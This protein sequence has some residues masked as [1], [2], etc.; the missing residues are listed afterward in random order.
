MTSPDITRI[1]L[2]IE[3]LPDAKDT[4]P[5]KFTP[6]HDAILLEFWNK[7]SKKDI[8]RIIGYAECTLRK[9]YEELTRG[10]SNA[11]KVGR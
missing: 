11:E 6:E 9:R 2:E 3:S 7:K 1:R 4:K 8:A 5:K 10:S